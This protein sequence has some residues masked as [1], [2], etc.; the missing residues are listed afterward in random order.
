MATSSSAHD[1]GST[2]TGTTSTGSI[3]NSSP[4]ANKFSFVIEKKE[5]GSGAFGKVYTARD[6]NDNIHAV[7]CCSTNENGITNMYELG[8]M[9]TLSHP[10]VCGASS[11]VVSPRLETEGHNILIF[12]EKGEGD[13]ITL[14]RNGFDPSLEQRRKWC[15]ELTLAVATLHCQ[16]NIIHCDIKGSNVIVFGKR[17]S[18]SVKLTDFGLSV[19][20]WLASTTYN[21]KVCTCTHRPLEC[22]LEM[23]WSYPLDIWS[24]AL[25]FFEIYYGKRLFPNQDTLEPS[26]G[27]LS[28]DGRRQ[29]LKQRSVNCL[30]DWFINGPGAYG[31]D[32]V[33]SRFDVSTFPINHIKYTLPPNWDDGRNSLFNQLIISMLHP[34]PE[35]RPNI[36]QIAR[37][38]F[39]TGLPI[40]QYQIKLPNVDIR[41]L[42]DIGRATRIIS[43]YCQNP[44][45]K[46]VA[47]ELYKRVVGLTGIPDGLKLYTLTFIA[48]KLVTGFAP[49][50]TMP[51]V[52]VLSTEVIICRHLEFRLL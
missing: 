1:R 49:L 29:R 25:T 23:D 30:L 5:I 52:D 28:P 19:K 22:F 38:P 33:R 41:L 8:I 14:M 15:W 50:S 9:S 46:H 10:H 4:S 37:H 20:K 44:Q 2:S 18:E 51:L 31:M 24:L 39:F 43:H 47:I 32:I 7:K 13:I 36:T 3:S 6:N 35:S 26:D 12:Q 40:V 42:T 48:T 21:H 16:F 17:G 34:I 45:I 11:I 27:S